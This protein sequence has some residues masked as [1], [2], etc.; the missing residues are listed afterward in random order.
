MLTA[1][2][3]CRAAV[4][5]KHSCKAGWK[6]CKYLLKCNSHSSPLVFSAP[7]HCNLVH[8][9]SYWLQMKMSNSFFSETPPGNRLSLCHSFQRLG[10]SLSWE[11]KTCR[12]ALAI[13]ASCPL[14]SGWQGAT[15]SLAD[16]CWGKEQDMC[17][18]SSFKKAEDGFTACLLCLIRIVP[19]IFPGKPENGLWNLSS[20][21]WLLNS[22]E[23]VQSCKTVS[24]ESLLAG[25]QDQTIGRKYL[26]DLTLHWIPIATY[27]TIRTLKNLAIC[28]LVINWIK[29]IFFCCF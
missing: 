19:W 15:E 16:S 22:Y 24:E 27:L 17:L 12:E 1:A 20:K 25:I 18:N 26:E 21:Q 4:L 11:S 5:A 9:F 23:H 29:I 8:F 13:P 10:E 28:F 14:Q 6:L 3:S 7:S 2:V